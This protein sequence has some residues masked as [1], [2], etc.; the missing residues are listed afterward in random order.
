MESDVFY[1]MPYFYYSDDD[2]RV[3]QCIIK[4]IYLEDDRIYADLLAQFH[5]SHPF[6]V[7]YEGVYFTDLLLL[8]GEID[9]FIEILTKL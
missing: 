3:S 8:G 1:P 4:D 6:D 2:Q 5:E 9:T 7:P